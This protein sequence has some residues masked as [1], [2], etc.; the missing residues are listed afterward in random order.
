MNEIFSSIAP[1]AS[2][3]FSGGALIVGYKIWG[4]MNR[5]YG[6][7]KA[8]FKSVQIQINTNGE[9]IGDA[10]RRIDKHLEAAGD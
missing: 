6:E 1:V 3:I 7:T 4:T 8:E 2:T 5:F 10:H 9:S